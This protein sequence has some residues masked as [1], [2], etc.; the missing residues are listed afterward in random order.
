MLSFSQISILYNRS[1]SK[2][3]TSCLSKNF[4]AHRLY[5]SP[6]CLILAL[7]F[8]HKFKSLFKLKHPTLP[9]LVVVHIQDR[10]HPLGTAHWRNKGGGGWNRKQHLIWSLY[11]RM[12]QANESEKTPI[13]TSQLSGCI[14]FCEYHL[15]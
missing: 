9:P 4:N 1:L 3:R 15:F 8:N 12:L 10:K 7:L 13:F 5:S 6:P 14:K 2:S 11:L